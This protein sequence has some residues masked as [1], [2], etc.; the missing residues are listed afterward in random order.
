MTA[1]MAMGGLMS[2]MPSARE[3]ALYD[4]RRKRAG[5]ATTVV[6]IAAIAGAFLTRDMG[7]SAVAAAAVLAQFAIPNWVGVEPQFPVPS[8]WAAVSEHLLSFGVPMVGVLLLYFVLTRGDLDFLG[9]IPVAVLGAL[10]YSLYRWRHLGISLTRVR[11][12]AARMP[13]G[14]RLWRHYLGYA[15]GLTA[16][17]LGVALTAEAQSSMLGAGSF[18]GAFLIVKALVDL[19]FSQPPLKAE[20]LSGAAV[21]L[22]LMSPIWF[23]LP[24]GAA[25]TGVMAAAEISSRPFAPAVAENAIVVVYMTV[26]S[27]VVFTSIVMVASVME[28]VAGDG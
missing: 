22:T 19:S 1:K 23:G 17:A 28:L 13:F 24:W 4:L 16:G 5:I 26:A 8:I 6:L 25:L 9:M 27:V 3:H 14:D 7:L 21:Q 20:R 10:V 2:D 11:G 12:A 18:G 15:A